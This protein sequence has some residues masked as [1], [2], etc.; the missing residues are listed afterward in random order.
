MKARGWP[1]GSTAPHFLCKSGHS[2]ASR[3]GGSRAG[4]L[5]LSTLQSMPEPPRDHEPLIPGVSSSL[6]GCPQLGTF[7]GVI[8]DKGS[9]SLTFFW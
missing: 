4:L 2:Q 8:L 1:E 3:S 9:L 6:F 7:D 5:T